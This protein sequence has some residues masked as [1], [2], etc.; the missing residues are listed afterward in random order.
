MWNERR[1]DSSP[2]QI[3]YEQLLQ[4]YGTD[5]CE[6]SHH[7]FGLADFRAYFQ[8]E[9]FQVRTLENQQVFDLDGL[10]GRLLSSSYA[11]EAGHPKHAPMLHELKT[12][13]EAHQV[14]GRVTFEYN[15]EVYYAR[16]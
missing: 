6:V 1:I 13:F 2:F 11:P 14:A 3:A 5:Y 16:F 9:S 8:N 10:T 12:I 15:T 7:Q 4:T